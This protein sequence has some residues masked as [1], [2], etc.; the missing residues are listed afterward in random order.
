ML[1]ASLTTFDSISSFHFLVFT[2]VK[3]AA[4][5]ELHTS[6]SKPKTHHTRLS[7][8]KTHSEFDSIGTEHNSNTILVRFII[9]QK[10]SCSC[11]LTWVQD[12]L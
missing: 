5:F 3:K 4:G 2:H 7:K 1:N 12:L 9:K 10:H 6:L 11:N 8:P